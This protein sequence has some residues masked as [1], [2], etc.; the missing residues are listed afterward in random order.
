VELDAAAE[1]GGGAWSSP[2][3]QRRG[4]LAI[5]QRLLVAQAHA[6]LRSPVAASPAPLLAWDGARHN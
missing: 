6:H 5:L 3:Q 4:P 1:V 2:V